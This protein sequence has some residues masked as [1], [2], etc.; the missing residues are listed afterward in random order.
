MSA[1]SRSSVLGRIRTSLGVSGDDK[2]RQ[3]TVRERLDA[4][5]RNL[6]PAR[7]QASKAD[8]LDLLVKMLRDQGAEVTRLPTLDDVPDAVAA[9]LRDNNLPA[10]LRLGADAI[11][12]GLP[13]DKTPALD[14]QHGHAG[15]EDAVGLSRATAAAAE[16]GTL[17]LVSGP[18]NPTSVNFLP[19]T[20]IALVRAADVV[21]PYEDAWDRLRAAYGEGALPR[22]VNLISGPSRTADI[23]QTIVMGAHGPRRLHVILVDG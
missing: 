21:G 13:W 22:T 18:D 3:E 12:A 8:C 10:R 7:A 2:V 20:H 23:E 1:A 15:G 19:D 6:V 14:R 16:T 11:L 4:H 5:P 9:W 17:F